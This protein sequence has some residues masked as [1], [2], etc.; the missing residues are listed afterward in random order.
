MEN[1]MRIT[2][3]EIR[4]M[5]GDD[6]VYYRG[7]RYFRENAVSNVTWSKTS[8][9][10]RAKVQGKNPYTVIIKTDPKISATCNCPDYVKN[11]GPCKHII[12][13]L[14]FISDYNERT[15]ENPKDPDKKQIFDII[16]YF[17]R[18][19]FKEVYGET[20]DLRVTISLPSIFKSNTGSAFVSLQVGN[21]RLYKVQNLKKFLTDYYNHENITLGKEFKFIEGESRFS[22]KSQKI[23]D[24]LL[25]IFEIQESLGRVYYSNLF[26]KSDMIFT[27]NMI[28]KL[29]ECIGDEP[30]NLTLSDK[31]YESIHFS[32]DNPEISLHITAKQE[33]VLLDYDKSYQII[34]L[35]DDGTLLL[36]EKVLYHPK[37]SFLKNYLPFYNTLGKEA[38]HFQ[39]EDKQKF[40]DMVLPNLHETMTINIPESMKENYIEDDLKISI[41]LDRNK[42][43]IAA[44]VYFTY[45]E[46]R[47]NPLNMKVPSGIVIIRQKAKEEKFTDILEDLGFL[48]YKDFFLLKEEE[49]IYHFITEGVH[50]LNEDHEVFYSDAFRT[51]S[52]RSAGSIT[53]SVKM[54]HALDLLEMDMSFDEIPKE[55][56]KEVYHSLQL[57]KKF[58]RLKNGIFIN[59]E[60]E[61]A[62]SGLRILDKFHLNFK[63]QGE[64]GF[65]LPKYAA[66]Y[67]EDY[68]GK[69]ESI[70][71]QSDPEFKKLVTEIV[72]D[73]RKDYTVSKKIQAD[74]RNYQKKGYSWLRMLAE[75]NLGGIL[76]DDMGLGKTLES[77]V[78]MVA[79][80]K[81]KHLIVCPTSLIYNWQDECSNFA[82]S[83]KTLVITGQPEIRQERIRSY[84]EY[85]ILITSYP[86]I[87]R[88]YEFYQELNIHTMFIDEAQFIKNPVSQNAKA[89]KRIPAKHK[90]ALTGT[91][92]ENSLTEL[93]SIFDFVL[94][95][96]LQTHH[97]FMETYERPIIRDEDKEALAELIRKINPFVLRRMKR[98][99]LTELPEK[100]ETKLLTEMT[101]K[102]SA[103][104]MSFIDNIKE[105]LNHSIEEK[106]YER[107]S[108][109]ILSAL[110]RL[111]QICCHPST[112]LSNYSGDSGKLE[113]LMEQL[114]GIL[115]NGHRVLI[116]SQFTSMLQIIGKRLEAAQMSHFYLDGANK[117]EER[118]DMVSRFNGGEKDVFLISLK[119][120]GTGINL[121]G[122][123]TVIHF[124]PWWNPAVE[125]QA[126]DRVY[127][128]GQTNTVHVIKLITKGTIEE[129][130]YKLQKRK[131]ELS[132]SVIDAKE[133]FINR[134]TKEE[135]E[136]LFR[137]D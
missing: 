72:A 35:T 104:Y 18:Q 126:T 118:M 119:A 33:E 17:N 75:H 112:F 125:E 114:P 65:L 21:K 89:V 128:I 127:R 13:T 106:G 44:E 8:K 27:K 120:G 42:N 38:L 102:Q 36:C 130:I 60:S 103:V 116:F 54:N 5:A 48:P 113:L 96:F 101:E 2:K 56:L 52:I 57:K 31:I 73:T 19:K 88:D 95:G 71:F 25:E 81:E 45:G 43:S 64:E 24:Y 78:Y 83:L 94:P 115:D 28:Y 22:K 66:V 124:D 136:D 123:D 92:I 10:Y 46:Y 131:R 67:L 16:E 100:I 134:L 59:L 108:F 51:I 41:Y 61:E 29:L 69:E 91:P 76:A 37:V 62:K 34:S 109:Q 110:T 23:L 117:P 70:T 82:P 1:I 135:I 32:N 79:Y 30:F 26:T 111:R 105:E 74:L 107:S 55:E 11:K 121:T 47:L 4:K 58:H 7:A 15:E 9:I 49:H 12:A 14:L 132:D 80:P 99:V 122:A 3:D 133:I 68:L 129:K 90:F 137:M 50:R 6:V 40:L 86:L 39:G 77:I 98:D 53:T 93:W 20:F 87:R 85:D 84:E 97:K 63:N